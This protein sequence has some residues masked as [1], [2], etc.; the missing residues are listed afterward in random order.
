M[1]TPQTSDGEGH[2]L[3]PRPSKALPE[4]LRSA[5]SHGVNGFADA[6]SSISSG[7]ST[8]V[9]QDAPP[10]IQ[11]LSSARK[12]ARAQAKHRLFHTIVYKPRVSHF[13]PRSDYRDFRGFFVLF[14]IS[15]TVMVITTGLRNIKET[16]HPLR[17]QV[18]ALLSRN[19][20]SLGLSDAAMVGSTAVS[21]LIQKMVRRQTGVL[22]WRKAGIWLQSIYQII[23]LTLWVEW[24]FLLGW[25]WTAQVFFALHTLTFLMK[26]HSYAFYNGHLSETERR[27]QELDKPETADRH[28]AVIYPSSPAR[29]QEQEADGSSDEDNSVEE[30]SQLRQDLATELTSP[31]GQVTYPQNLTLYNY[32]DYILCPTLC[33]ELEYPRTPHINWF[34][35]F[36][37]T[38]AVF[39]CIF[40]MITVSEE[41]ITPVLAE[42]AIRL[43]Y[44]TTFLDKALVLA[45]TTSMLLFP[46]MIIFLLVFL[47]IWE[48]ILGAFAEITCFADRH[49][50]SDWW[51]SSDWLEFSREWNIP[52]YHFLRRHVFFSSKT[53]LSTPAAMTITFLISALGHELIMGCITKKLRGYGFIAMMLQL[54]IVALQRSPL[55]RGRWVFNNA[56]FWFS[57]ILGLSG[58]CSLYVLV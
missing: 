45:E 35:L 41:F 4:A 44:L 23:W 10:S 3:R 16:G 42:S 54:P 40:L 34:E 7:R 56:A 26:M 5:G 32:A 11:S 46:F 17:V 29:L 58:M 49:F 1:A 6:P 52:V 19:V 47:V 51:N 25:T 24:P 39:G 31:L 38:L 15:L 55:I 57:M 13:D 9:P 12:Q 18:Y 20:V 22:R 2:L 53:Y 28:K 48:Y 37:K 50:Y 43:R 30:L 33:Y 8:P 21:L 27:L 36:A 14:W